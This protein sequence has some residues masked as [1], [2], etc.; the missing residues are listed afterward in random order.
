MENTFSL[1]LSL[2]TVSWVF[3]IARHYALYIEDLYSSPAPQEVGILTVFWQVRKMRLKHVATI[4]PR[5]LSWEVL[6]L[7][8]TLGVPS[9][10][11]SLKM[12]GFAPP[13]V[14]NHGAEWRWRNSTLLSHR[15]GK[16][17]LLPHH[18]QICKKEALSSSLPSLAYF[19]VT[20]WQRRFPCF[21]F[22]FFLP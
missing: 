5:S 12:G 7:E 1:P 19:S 16:S 4:C 10:A 3:S 13:T 9:R 11:H 15:D 17:T 8:Q 22:C 2:F 18:N 14:L 6:E 21:C 20:K